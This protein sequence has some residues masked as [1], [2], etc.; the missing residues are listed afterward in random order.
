MHGSI[1]SA[2]NPCLNQAIRLCPVGMDMVPFRSWA[3]KLMT[4]DN[5]HY[6][7]LVG[8]SYVEK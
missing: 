1:I 6:C 4:K 7:G 5:A 3:S 2:L 8:G